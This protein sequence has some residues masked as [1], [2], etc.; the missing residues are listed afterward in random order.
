MLGNNKYSSLEV[1]QTS[2]DDEAAGYTLIEVD[3]S[4]D[5]DKNPKP[6]PANRVSKPTIRASKKP[7]K[8]IRQ[9]NQ[10][11]NGKESQRKVEICGN[12]M[13][14]YI[15]AHKLG[16]ST[17][18]RVTS[19]SSSGA[20]CKDMKH[21]IMPTLEKK[22]GEI[23]LHVGTNDLKTSS[24]KTIVKDIVALKDFVVK[25]SSST[26]VTTSEL[27]M[28]TDDDALNNKIQH[29]NTLL[30][31]NCAAANIPLIEHSNINN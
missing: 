24:A 11:E 8:E 6:K 7:E 28:R 27:I 17:N 19:K 22:P 25:A 10:Q 30:R 20:K 14:K 4:D 9:Q 16:R 31:Q 26:K 12:S 2:E 5:E 23:I 21:Y 18:D 29:V 1:E 15:K 13:T 3:T